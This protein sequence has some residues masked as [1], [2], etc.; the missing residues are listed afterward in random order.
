MRCAKALRAAGIGKG[1]VVTGVLINGPEAVVCLLGAT[2]IGAI[3]SGC[4]PD[5]GVGGI[6]D[7]LGQLNPKMLF[8]SEVH[9]TACSTY[10]HISKLVAK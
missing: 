8:F 10:M 9:F 2:S 7:R 6:S 1:D 5:F 4:S 3:W